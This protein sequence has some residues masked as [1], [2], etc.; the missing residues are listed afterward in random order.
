MQPDQ[1]QTAISLDPITFAVLG[2]SFRALVN[3]M[4][5][6]LFR[7]ALSPVITEG[8]DIGGALFDRDGLLVA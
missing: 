3:E 5:V 7:S 1:S 2:G 6:A 4:N 8:R